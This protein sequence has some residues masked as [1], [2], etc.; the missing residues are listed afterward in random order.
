MID[1]DVKGCQAKKNVRWIVK[2]QGNSKAQKIT[3]TSPIRERKNHEIYSAEVLE[4]I[5]TF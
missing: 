4:A 2:P 5:K 3:Q 1:H